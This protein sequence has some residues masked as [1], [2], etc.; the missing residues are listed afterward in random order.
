MAGF[1]HSAERQFDAAAG[2]IAVDENLAAPH[3]PS[4]A[5]RAPGVARPDARD[6]AIRRAI[7]EADG[8]GFVIEGQH[9]ENRAE[10]FVIGER[11]AARHVPTA[12]A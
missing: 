3:R 1:L 4:D 2:A 11:V 5:N 9:R 7:G 8:V 12:S 6:Q 10:D